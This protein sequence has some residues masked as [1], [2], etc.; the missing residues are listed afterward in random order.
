MVSAIVGSAT[1]QIVSSVEGSEALSEVL[2]VSEVLFELE[3]FSEKAIS[4]KDELSVMH[5]NEPR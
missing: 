5:A 1:E 2:F 3:L 4:P